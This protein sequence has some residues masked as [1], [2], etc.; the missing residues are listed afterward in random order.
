M[1]SST[2][3][4]PHYR[5][6]RS[7]LALVLFALALLYAW[8][9]ARAHLQAIALLDLVSGEKLPWLLQ[10]TI[11]DPVTVQQI[12]L[13]G[14]IRARLYTPK[15]HP[16]APGIVVLHG[17]HYL[18]IDEPR[19][20]SFASGLASC[21][22]QVFTPELP[23]IRDY[24]I[25]ANS[26]TVIG[27]STQWF[28]QQT[29]G[30]VGV[31]G[32][33][34]SGGLALIAA[35][36]PAYASDFKFIVAV[37]SQN[38][39]NRV[40]EYYRTGRALRPDGTYEVLPPHE[41]G[42]LVLEYEHLEDFVPAADIPA[43]RSVLKAHLYED[44]IAEKQAMLQLTSAQNTEAIYL[45]NAHSAHTQLLLANNEQLRSREMEALSP[46]GKLS[47]LTTPV[48]L[49]HGEADNIIPASEALW[50]AQELPATSLKE[51]LVSPIIS[52]VGMEN[53]LTPS[54]LR[55]ADDEWQLIHF[56]ARIMQTAAAPR[57]PLAH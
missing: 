7:Y 56:F 53:S 42:T 14:N 22:L 18:G 27:T 26:I 28:A 9:I 37:G 5:R 32:L 51:L 47:A 25:D 50:M 48:F 6:K 24:H 2:P 49:L 54:W 52:H 33:S 35:T 3:R 23:D 4:R 46:A 31:M 21:G 38:S 43:I 13:P 16:N 30:P 44:P 10:H 36:E 8:P 55:H 11:A 17:V 1:P 12:Q 45:M 29:H 57:V 20:I 34:F 15:H 40:A 19:M 41:Y 39:M